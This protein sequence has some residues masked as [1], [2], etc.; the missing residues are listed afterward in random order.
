MM[1]LMITA[2][3]YTPVDAREPGRA[4]H[5]RRLTRRPARDPLAR[6]RPGSRGPRR[7][8]ASGRRGSACSTR[9]GRSSTSTS[10]APARRST[11]RSTSTGHR[12]QLAAWE[13]LAD[14]PLRRDAHLRRAG[15]ADRA[16][17]CRAGRRCGER[18]QPALDRPALP[19]R[20]RQ[21]RRPARVRGRA[22]REGGVAR[23]GARDPGDR[24][25]PGPPSARPW[26]ALPS[27]GRARWGVSGS[28]NPKS[29]PAG[30][31]AVRGTVSSGLGLRTR[32]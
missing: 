2:T 27:P 24:L 18:A 31:N 10:P 8:H 29:A 32:C 30:P 28:L 19:P 14:D 20:R 21:R 4:A 3:T 12:F 1:T 25:K 11:S 13:A 26:L 23:P 7:R 17:R 22:R 15:G 9:R 16:A 5:A 6:R